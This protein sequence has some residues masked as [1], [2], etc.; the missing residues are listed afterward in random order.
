MENAFEKGQVNGLVRKGDLVEAARHDSNIGCALD[1]PKSGLE[2]RFVK[3][4]PKYHSL[5]TYQV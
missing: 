3:F 2:A 1:L 4:D 5:T